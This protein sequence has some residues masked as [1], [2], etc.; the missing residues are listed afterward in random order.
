[1]AYKRFIG[2]N[3]ASWNTSSNWS[4]SGVPGT[5]DEA[6][7]EVARNV[8]G[9]GST[10]LHLVNVN[11]TTLSLNFTSGFIFTV[12]GN[13]TNNGT[14]TASNGGTISLGA[15]ND[16]YMYC[17]VEFSNIDFAISKSGRFIQFDSAIVM[18]DNAT[19]NYTGGRGLI[20]LNSCSDFRMNGNPIQCNRIVFATSSSKTIRLNANITGKTVST[21]SPFASITSGVGASFPEKTGKFIGKPKSG[22]GALAW[23]GGIGT[24]YSTALRFE[25]WNADNGNTRTLNNLSNHLLEPVFNCQIGNGTWN[26]HNGVSGNFGG[27]TTT[28]STNTVNCYVSNGAT[29][30][31]S[32]PLPF[33]TVNFIKNIGTGNSFNITDCRAVTSNLNSE[34]VTYYL[35]VSGGTA[36][37]TFNLNGTNFTTTYYVRIINSG[38]AATISANGTSC[39]Y[40]F[41]WSGNAFSQN[42]AAFTLNCGT[43]GSNSN[44][45]YDNC[46]DNASAPCTINMELG[47]HYF[48]SGLNIVGTVNF[49]RG[50]IHLNGQP[51][52]GTF[53]SNPSPTS[54]ARTFNWN[55]YYIRVNNQARTANA[56]G[57]GNVN[58]VNA[59]TTTSTSSM[60]SSDSCDGGIQV[61]TTG[62]VN[63]GLWTDSTCPRLRFKAFGTTASSRTFASGNIRS[64]EIQ[65]PCSVGGSTPVYKSG[66]TRV[67]WDG[68]GSA[69]NFNSL[70]VYLGPD[71]GGT[72]FT[73]NNAAALTDDTKRIQT[74]ITNDTYG[75]ASGTFTCSIVAYAQGINLN[76]GLGSYTLE[77]VNVQGYVLCVPTFA[78]TN[79]VTY[80]WR[81]VIKKAT[82]SGFVGFS[83]SDEFRASIQSTVGLTT[84]IIENVGIDVKGNQF[85]VGNLDVNGATYG[86]TVA[87]NAPILGELI[88]L[89]NNVSFEINSNYTFKNIRFSYSN[90]RLYAWSDFTITGQLY[91]PGAPVVVA[92]D[93]TITFTGADSTTPIDLT[94]T[95]TG[96]NGSGANLV[97]RNSGGGDRTINIRNILFN[98]ITNGCTF[99]HTG[100]GDGTGWLYINNGSL[101]GTISTLQHE[102]NS[103]SRG[104]RSSGTA[105]L[106]VTNP[107]F[108]GNSTN[109]AY[110]W[111]NMVKGGG[112]SANL[113]YLGIRN[114]TVTPSS[115]W[116]ADN[117]IDYGT[118]SGWNITAGASYS[119][120]P[121]AGSVNEGANIT[122]N[123]STTGI[124]NGTTLYWTILHSTTASADFSAN[125]GSFTI[126]SDA[127]SFTITTVADATT[128]GA[129][130]FAVEIRT[131]STSGAVVAT[132]TS[133]T[134]NDTSL[135]PSYS[136]SPVVGN[137]NE[138][139]AL[140]INVTTGNVNDGT[141]LYWTISHVTSNASD[142]VATSG[143][144]TIN[145]NAG[146]FT[147]TPSA[148]VTTEG[149]ETYAV[150]IRTGSTSGTVVAT[151]SNITINDTSLTPSY[152]VYIGFFQFF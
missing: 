92:T 112:G 82:T 134:V 99:T 132:S 3:G 38:T 109:R 61:E 139:T 31:Y 129:Q 50:A 77:D 98:T 127:G 123:V 108:S 42:T 104:I 44:F 30:N 32:C 27:Q 114:S 33:T 115:T 13:V 90:S 6:V 29:F 45:Y 46:T 9:T 80:T 19:G 26:W 97:I 136:A 37:K 69:A 151:T 36:A 8:I 122:I 79:P 63:M 34:A 148:D 7:F 96:F 67:T 105:S 116:Y 49:N 35:T 78:S 14:L 57:T 88:S 138:G 72:N 66:T 24:D 10:I 135:S 106:T 47:N 130:T 39:N 5:A 93:R 83:A 55:G 20:T 81:K 101:A 70:R 64:L 76:K 126:N 75:P 125:S 133:I 117:S 40:Y 52:V 54:N 15:N 121:A 65:G 141:T 41:G 48:G 25:F 11:N 91:G 118:N 113:N 103:V 149:S 131:G 119:V 89:A 142:F 107:N 74:V 60:D 16:C 87:V 102:N 95:P 140:T 120:T 53:N 21:T 100:S 84:H 137:V 28:T 147:V 146:S 62:T 150:Q 43:T 94:G 2:A 56:H 51:I 68:V 145:S 143:S 111:G 18:K 4:P 128:E 23:S 73:Y 71:S 12:H 124:T 152:P 86:G 144:F 22:T 1:M 85:T 110:F 59:T 17:G 58:I